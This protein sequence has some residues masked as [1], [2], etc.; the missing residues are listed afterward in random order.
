MN[1]KKY[2]KAELISKIKGLKDNS[3]NPNSN[4]M[5]ILLSLKSLL[6]K[7]T[8]IA[9][10]VK[11]FKKFSIF[12]RI[13]R[14]FNTIL[15]SIFG[16][17][18]IDFYEIE[19]LSNIIHKI[20]DIFSNFY[21]STFGLFKKVDVPIKETP[22]RLNPSQPNATGINESNRIIERFTKII[23]NKDEISPEPVVE[24]ENNPYY[25]NKYI[26]LVALLLLSG[27]TWYYWDDILPAGTTILSWFKSLRSKPGNKPDGT[28]ENTPVI[29]QNPSI[30][31]PVDIIPDNKSNL[32]TLK[33]KILSKFYKK[34]GNPLSDDSSTDIKLGTTSPSLKD[35][36]N[37]KLDMHPTGEFINN[38]TNVINLINKFHD[39]YESNTLTMEGTPDRT[40]LLYNFIRGELFILSSSFHLYYMDWIKNDSIDN[41][42]NKFIALEK[43]ISRDAGI[44]DN[45]DENQSETYNEVALATANE[46]DIWSD[47]AMSPKPLSP[48]II[49]EDKSITEQQAKMLFKAASH[50]SS[51]EEIHAATG[52]PVNTDSDDSINQMGQFFTD[53]PIE[54]KAEFIQGSSKDI[55]IPKENP[56][57]ETLKNANISEET[58]TSWLD[59]LKNLRSKLKKEDET[60]EIRVSPP[61][62]TV[63]EI[64]EDDNDL[65]DLLPHIKATTSSDLMK[66]VNASQIPTSDNKKPKF[67]NLPEDWANSLKGIDSQRKEYGTPVISKVGLQ[68]PVEEQIKTSPLMHKP[69][70]SNLLE[71]TMNL[72]DEDPTGIDESDDY[73]E[74]SYPAETENS[75]S[76]E[77]EIKLSD[78]NWREEIKYNIQRGEPQDRFIEFDFGK[79][80]DKITKVFIILNDGSSQYFNPHQNKATVQMIKWDNLASTNP[81]TKVL[82]LFKIFIIDSNAKSCELYSNPD[83]KILDCYKTNSNRFSKK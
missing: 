75:K 17:S 47:K 12:N 14:I 59:S 24:E 52:V 79:H 15:F 65:S 83:V 54:S 33:D 45:I 39:D 5:T 63:E 21:L 8:L 27:I 9:V 73:L 82:D 40:F 58:R 36:Q 7:F 1:L 68:T 37:M 29:P 42:I 78:I 18:L 76:Q 25:K 4:L 34:D 32:Q 66:E 80:F 44:N 81:N 51:K 57:N 23:N 43:E 46:Q 72:F 62:A 26:L 70:I 50:K 53:K 67:S 22:T 74:Q 6:L 48:L 19:I 56:I 61:K 60:P 16:I 41:T 69:S 3:N 38:S 28:N 77:P 20:I 2:T 35:L 64:H 13:W 31:D 55:N 10:I 71:D 11:I 49:S 30:V